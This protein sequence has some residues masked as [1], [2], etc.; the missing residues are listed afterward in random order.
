MRAA[1]AV[2]DAGRGDAR[3]A[4]RLTGRAG[5]FRARFF[6]PFGA[7]AFEVRDGLA[8]FAVAF[9]LVR[10]ALVIFRVAAA[11]LRVPAPFL[12]RLFALVAV[13]FAAAVR[14]FVVFFAISPPR[15]HIL[16]RGARLYGDAR[17][18]D[19]WSALYRIRA[20]W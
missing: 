16:P 1:F 13:R 9:F 17:H 14:F 8:F 6:E 5:A 20:P 15:A 11:C 4:D 2:R 18:A 12:P 3:F 19:D 7:A 10:A